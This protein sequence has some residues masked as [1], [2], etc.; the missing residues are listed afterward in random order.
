MIFNLQIPRL[1]DG[2]LFY[3]IGDFLPPNPPKQ[4][5]ERLVRIAG[6][7]VLH[8]EPQSSDFDRTISPCHA[9]PGS[10]LFSCRYIVVNSSNTQTVKHSSF[11]VSVS[12]TW[13]LDC[14]SQFELLNT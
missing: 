1:F 9:K 12:S 13:I 5:F 8:E 2:C 14:L 4:D 11:G 3:F 7:T 6:G 10:D